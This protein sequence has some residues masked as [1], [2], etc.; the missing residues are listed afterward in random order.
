MLL[1]P[2]EFIDSYFQEMENYITKRLENR[3]EVTKGLTVDLEVAVSQSVDFAE[4]LIDK[5]LEEQ[6]GYSDDDVIE[7]IM[8]KTGLEQ[9]FL[10]LFYW[11]RL[12]YEME[13]DMWEHVGD[14]LD[15]GGGPLFRREIVGED[16]ALK[17]VC[18]KC[19]K[20]AAEDIYLL[21][22]EESPLINSGDLGI[23]K[24]FDKFCSFIDLNNPS[25]TKK[26]KVLGKKDAFNLNSCLHFKREGLNIHRCV[27][28]SLGIS[29]QN[30]NCTRMILREKQTFRNC[31]TAGSQPFVQSAVKL[32]CRYR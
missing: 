4:E 5:M 8:Q 17:I 15:C 19:G 29:F 31:S 10:D 12:C 25:L 26:K 3:T 28:S 24:D 16:Y 23:V 6:N 1:V 9:E 7:Y 22:P 21:E 30:C 11:Y 13:H 2:D 27:M 20:E 14:C 18:Q 32:S